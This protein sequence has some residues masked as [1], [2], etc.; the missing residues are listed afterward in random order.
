MRTVYFSSAIAI[1]ALATQACASGGAG[2]PAAHPAAEV[3][4]TAGEVS[5]TERSPSEATPAAREAAG[6]EGAASN[7]AGQLTCRTK[8]VLDGTSELYL[9]W[10]GE[11]AK[12]VLRRVAPSG[13][14]YVER[15]RAERFKGAIIADPPESIDLVDHVAVVGSQNGK[16]FMRVGNAQQPWV[17]C[18]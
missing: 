18:D 16:Q 2:A 13:M 7:E 15:V 9:E 10:N 6:V 17:A 14:V 1:V 11:T 8:S 3:S 12:G 5:T 4:T